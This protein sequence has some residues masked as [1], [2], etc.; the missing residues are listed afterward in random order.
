MIHAQARALLLQQQPHRL[1]AGD[2]DRVLPGPMRSRRYLAVALIL[3]HLEL[4][5]VHVEGMIHVGLVDDFPQFGLASLGDDVDAVHIESGVIDEEPH[6]HAAGAHAHLLGEDEATTHRRRPPRR[7][8]AQLL[9]Q[10]WRRFGRC[11]RNIDRQQRQPRIVR[12]ARPHPTTV[13]VERGQL[14]HARLVEGDDQFDTLGRRQQNLVDGDRRFQKSAVGANH[15]HRGIAE[16]QSQEARIGGIEQAEAPLG[17]EPDGERGAL[18]AVDQDVV[19]DASVHQVDHRALGHRA[20]FAKAQIGEEKHGVAIGGRHGI[21]FR[22]DQ[23]DA[24]E[25][26]IHLL[27]RLAV[28][29]RVIPIGAGAVGRQVECI[30]ALGARC[31]RVHRIAVLVG[32]H[33]H[34]MP[35][36]GA[37]LAR[38]G[39]VEV[40]LDAVALESLDQRT[41]ARTVVGEDGRVQTFNE[42]GFRQSRRQAG[43]KTASF[44]RL[45][46]EPRQVAQRLAFLQRQL[47]RRRGGFGRHVVPLMTAHA[48][49]GVHV[50]P[51]HLR[52]RVATGGQHGKAGGQES[53][54]M[55]DFLLVGSCRQS[56]RG[57]AGA[58]Q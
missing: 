20:I 15:R 54:P 57:I 55:H 48:R 4:G 34:A 26:A 50:M 41:G 39:V 47:R 49:H 42:V 46:G 30:D 14:H 51:L 5:S 12:P 17:A 22:L 18:L 53:A 56:G 43:A 33:R 21:G 35:V 32:R 9:R 25:A 23:E 10:R 40:D 16:G 11:L 44:R 7:D 24:G 29:M 13:I 28:R 52:E 45:V 2:I 36:D 8:A 58:L 31:D 19:A 1:A 27:G 6:F 38:N 37:F 3:D